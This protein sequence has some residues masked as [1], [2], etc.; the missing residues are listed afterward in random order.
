MTW[1]I[2]SDTFLRSKCGRFDLMLGHDRGDGRR[3]VLI[4]AELGTVRRFDCTAAADIEAWK[5]IK[6][7]KK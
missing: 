1:E 5:L 7:A 3:W 2:V 6:G 4:D